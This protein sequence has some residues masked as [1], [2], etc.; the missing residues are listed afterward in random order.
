[1]WTVSALSIRLGVS[2]ESSGQPYSP[3]SQFFPQ[4]NKSIL[5]LNYPFTSF[6]AEKGIPN[7]IQQKVTQREHL[8]HQE[9]LPC[10]CPYLGRH[11]ASDLGDP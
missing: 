8:H 10:P 4:S 9:H 3:N 6:Q 7:E 1:M 11:E 2:Y 5:L